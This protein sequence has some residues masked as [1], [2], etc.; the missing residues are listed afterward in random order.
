MALEREM[1]SPPISRRSV[2]QF[3][4]PPPPESKEMA[5]IYEEEQGVQSL[6]SIAPRVIIVRL[7][8][9]TFIRVRDKSKS[10]G[11][12]KIFGPSFRDW[13]TTV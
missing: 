11:R 12:I 4:F 6:R 1:S 13:L 10:C 3:T 8:D 9:R 2:A 5:I 7:H